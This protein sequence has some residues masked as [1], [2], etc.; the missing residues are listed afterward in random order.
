MLTNNLFNSDMPGISET[1]LRPGQT[2]KG[3]LAMIWFGQWRLSESTIYSPFSIM[4]YY[5]LKKHTSPFHTMC[6]SIILIK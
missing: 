3:Q 4:F 5:F 1:I 6:T 2:S